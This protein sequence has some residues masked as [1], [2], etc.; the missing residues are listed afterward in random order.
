ML[1]IFRLGFLP[2]S[3][4]GINTCKVKSVYK[5]K[6]QPQPIPCLLLKIRQVT[7]AQWVI[8]Y[9]LFFN[10]KNQISVKYKC[11]SPYFICLHWSRFASSLWKVRHYIIC[12]FSY[13]AW[14]VFKSS[15]E[16]YIKS[17][18]NRGMHEEVCFFELFLSLASLN[19]LMSR[20]RVLSQCNWKELPL[21]LKEKKYWK[22]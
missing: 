12:S 19:S 11:H 16:Q 6:T 3:A 4:L 15:V 22:N 20:K 17:P 9:H 10:L 8:L 5:L 2:Y 7:F 18:L 14:R 13:T 21:K 1:I